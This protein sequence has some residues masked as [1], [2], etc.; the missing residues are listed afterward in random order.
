M[1]RSRMIREWRRRLGST[2]P[3]L[4][5]GE[6]QNEIVSKAHI[7]VKVIDIDGNESIFPRDL[8]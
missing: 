1:L 5:P 8:P 6:E 4:L 7:A 2:H 3:A